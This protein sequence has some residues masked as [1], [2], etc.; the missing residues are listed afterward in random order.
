MGDRIDWEIQGVP[1]E[2]VVTNLREVDWGRL[3]TN[4]FVVFPPGP[5]DEAPQSIVLVGHLAGEEARAELQRDLVGA[6]PNVSVMDAT[7]LLRAA[8]AIVGQVSLA[9]RFMAGFTLATGL[10]VLLAAASTAR[11]QRVR[12]ALLLRTLGSRGFVVR[13]I[14]TTESLLLGALAATVGL[15]LAVLAAWALVHFLFEQ[16]FHWPLRDLGLLWLVA[17]GLS[18]ALGA[19]HARPALRRPPLAGLRDAN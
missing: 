7:T 8:E 4:F 9:V 16:T 2:S 18:T 13:R 11:F 15:G 3:A 10:V 5:L 19:T 6:F 1:I 17:V 12:E 14:L